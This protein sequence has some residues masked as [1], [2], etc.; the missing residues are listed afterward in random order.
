VASARCL[1]VTMFSV[2]STGGGTQL[3][4]AI[5]TKVLDH[6]L[7][8][9]NRCD[10]LKFSDASI[11][12][13]LIMARI[14]SEYTCPN[15]STL[16]A[17]LNNVLDAVRLN[18]HKHRFIQVVADRAEYMDHEHLFG[19]KVHSSF[20]S[21]IPDIRE[22]GNCLAVECN[23]AAVFHLMRAVE[24]GLRALASNLGVKRVRASKKP[25]NK[26]YTPLPYTEWETILD[27]LQDA[28]DA[29]MRKLTRGTAKQKLQEFYYPALQDIRGFRDAWRNHTM[30]TRVEYGRD[31][32]ITVCAHVKR[33]MRV[34]ATRV[35]E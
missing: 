23:T 35:S 2:P 19:E 14:A 31:D 15:S 25:A 1:C 13:S 30:H 16:L 5:R 9:R 21:A 33:L 11:S 20:P 3:D 34:L 18:A 6:L 4:D 10:G 17:E 24:W 26:K 12:I 27:N 28:V 29:K 32:A 7:S 22:A 8:L